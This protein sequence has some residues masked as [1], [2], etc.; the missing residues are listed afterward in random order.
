MVGGVG[1]DG[2]YGGR[3]DGEC[4][5]DGG[6]RVGGDAAVEWVILRWLM[7][8]TRRMVGSRGLTPSRRKSCCL[9]C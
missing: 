3:G 6:C 8:G 1:V 5:W 9:D 2:F 7:V 4:R